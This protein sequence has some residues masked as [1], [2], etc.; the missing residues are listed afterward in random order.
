MPTLKI[1]GPKRRE[2]ERT[3][4]QKSLRQTNASNRP[5]SQHS[6]A[7]S[8]S[9]PVRRSIA[10]SSRRRSSTYSAK[11][12]IHVGRRVSS[13]EN[14]ANAHRHKSPKNATKPVVHTSPIVNG[15]ERPREHSVQSTEDEMHQVQLP[16]LKPSNSYPDSDNIDVTMVD[17][18]SL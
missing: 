3:K 1:H 11:G 10:T 14:D 15:T 6:N 13:T 16:K 17:L 8:S 4:N 12:T 9:P 7:I 18:V 5:G 2:S